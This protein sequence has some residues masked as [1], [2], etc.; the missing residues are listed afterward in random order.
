MRWKPFLFLVAFLILGLQQLSSQ[1]LSNRGKEFWL[2]YGHNSL[3]NIT[4]INSQQLVIYLSTEEAAN[5]TVSVNGTSFSQNYNIPANTVRQTV[6]I[7]KSGVNDARILTEGLN[8]RGIHIVSDVPIVAYAHQYG[9]SSSGA[10]MLMPVETFGYT[11]YSLNYSQK[12][13]SSSPA[14]SWFFIVASENN[15]RVEITPSVPTQGGRPENQ[16]F[17]VNL[18]KGQIYN[19][20]GRT[21]G[22]FGQDLTG[23][24]IKSIAGSDGKCHPIGV[25]SGASRMV[26]CGTSGEF[27][28]QQIFPAS[29]WGTKYLTYSSINTNNIGV[30][31]TNFY[32]VAVRDPSTKVW[33]NGVELTNLIDNFY[34]E[35]STSSGDYIE[36]DKPILVGQYVPSMQSCSV[37]SGDGDP[38][39]FFLSPIEQA[40]NKATFYAAANQSITNVYVSIIVPNGGLNSLTI[41]GNNR[42]DLTLPHPRNAN[43]QIVVER[44]N[45]NQQHTIQS[46]SAFTAITYGF[47]T[48]E[49]YGYN[50]GTLV[51]NLDA[52]PNIENSLNTTSTSGFTC[53]KSPFK[54]S[55]KLT[56]KPTQI[57]WKFS[58]VSTIVPNV[59]T[60]LLNPIPVDSSFIGNRKYYEYRL[61][62]DYT[63]SDTGTYNIPISITAPNIDNCDNTITI[64]YTAK[65][66]APP[67]PDFTFSYTGCKSDSASLF[68]TVLPGPFNITSYK[69]TFDDGTIDSFKNVKKKFATQGSHNVKLRI[70]SDNGCI[71]DTTKPVVT[72]PPPTA[73]F[74]ITPSTGCGPTTVTFTDSSSYAGG[75][76]QNWY[77]NFGNGQTLNTNTNA[78]QTQTYAAG[79]YIIKHF[80]QSGTCRGDTAI[81][82][83]KIY[84]KPVASFTVPAGCLPDS[85]AQFINT[86][87]IADSQALSYLWNFGDQNATATNPNTSTLES[88][89][90]KYSAYGTYNVT[91]TVTTANGCVNTVTIPFTIGGFSAAINYSIQNADALCVS[92][93]V[94]LTNEVNVTRDSV[95]RID[96]YWDAIG[97]ATVFT[98][99]N[100]PVQNGVYTHAYPTFSSPAT[101]AYT[102]KMVVYSKGGCISEKSKVI[103]LHAVPVVTFGTL[104]GACV[105]AAPTSIALGA[106]SN[107]LTGT[108]VYSGPG[109][110][111]AGIFNPAIAGVG[112]H[113][114]K[115]EFTTAGGCIDSAKRTIN[116]FAK[117][118]VKWGFINLCDSTEFSDTSIITTGNITSW[119]WN[120]GDATSEVRTS[121][122][123]FRKIYRSAGTYDAS[124]FVLSNNGC[125]S[126]TST[127]PI[128]INPVPVPAFTVAN[129]N[130]LCSQ[131][132][133]ALTNVTSLG[134]DVINKLEIYWDFANQPT[135]AETHNSPAANAR[136]T[137]QYATFTAPESKTVTIKWVMYTRGSCI[138]E[139]T[140]T[141][142][143]HALPVLSFSRLASL[144]FNS[145]PSSVAQALATNGVTG[146]GV[147]SG[148]G[149]T[150]SG[151]FNPAIAGE[152]QHPITYTFTTIG[153][154]VDSISTVIKVLPVPRANF[155]FTSV[156][157][158]DSTTFTDSS[159]LTSG[160]ITTWNWDF[161]DG[162][163]AIKNSN[164][165]F[166]KLY[167]NSG[168]FNA[169]LTVVSDSGCI[170]ETVTKPVIVNAIPLANF[171][172]SSS[173]CLPSGQLAFTNRS[174]LPGGAASDL[175]YVWDFG[176]GSSTS[177]NPNPSH[178]YAASSNYTIRLTVTSKS[179]CVSDTSKSFNAFL[180]KPIA[181]FNVL[182]PF[183]CQGISS[184]FTDSSSAP[185]STISNWRWQFGDG[186]TSNSENPS[187]TYSLP[188]NFVVRLTVTTPE[189]CT[190]DT[191]KQIKV[192]VQ[193]KVDAGTNLYIN[194]G[195][196]TN[197]YPVVNDTTLRFLWTP[198]TYL[199]N[200]TLLRPTLINPMFT[201]TYKLTATGEGGCTASDTVRVTILKKLNVPNAFSP[202]GDGINDTWNIQNLSDY[203]GSVLELFNRYG[204]RVYQTYNFSKPWDGT[205]NGTTLPVGVYYYI[206]DLKQPGATKMVGS[207]TLLR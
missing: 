173:V 130:S 42:F 71:G 41:D 9:E 137:H 62:R 146:T 60:T 162:E 183:I 111:A 189:G 17:T 152:G 192:Y 33:R 88:P 188:G 14:Y 106:V 169:K 167:H 84:S 73:T 132:Q 81:K 94:Q 165:A 147:Y 100:S 115:Y 186:F 200:D 126:D 204:Q 27:M 68:G 31:N 80:A 83:L 179:G 11:Y 30:S 13:N 101:V 194:E 15:T 20:F 143:L 1:N 43:Y 178:T 40:I 119:N 36:S 184:V 161:S 141:I 157:V 91:L 4:P 163:T 205:L 138:T 35:F 127:K 61:P 76:I 145:S 93:R 72:S 136:Y 85:L 191:S 181:D 10:T 197:L 46:D 109:T 113:T 99:D 102:I 19:V 172:M 12:T 140:K 50:A 185:N 175:N 16:I 79:T 144:C 151:N 150:P 45:V 121:G 105:N 44:V 5:V 48:F 18:N 54:F 38:E 168:S 159:S 206:I 199:N 160:N 156:C 22:I 122:A 39:I 193:P 67:K 63:F 89:T 103:T 170:S 56:Y 75:P 23:S 134:T 196:L 29:A 55:V 182:L 123:S 195:T 116:V 128:T 78:A 87:S 135:V 133:V 69:W 155:G 86:T 153:G 166:N 92:N 25:F 53:P 95:Y 58:Q 198:A 77:W 117:P 82:T 154:C 57:V 118:T 64:I 125:S 149:T 107:G 148:A 190:A 110:T 180:P 171:T 98:T 131:N 52:L 34:Y 26:I 74:G 112:V 65:V 114:I 174:S 96:L 7:P 104:L 158:T 108:G 120:F 202:N 28:Q 24:K 6:E 8:S 142:T 66:N 207:V 2:G 90:H 51:N 177:T 129:E 32:R 21:S 176:D 3:F 47:G 124:L 59:D 201:Q 70:I 49:S 187:K 203:P 139:Q 37:Y 164:T 97:R